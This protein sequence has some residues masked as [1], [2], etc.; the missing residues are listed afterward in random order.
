MPPRPGRGAATSCRCAAR[1]RGAGVGVGGGGIAGRASVGG[2]PIGE[3]TIAATV[4]PPEASSS[5]LH[6]LFP[7]TT[8]QFRASWG[9]YFTS[10]AL[11]VASPDGGRDLLDP[12]VAGDGGS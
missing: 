11:A 6:F 8:A 3:S 4:N 7:L 2:A 12:V 1:A 5:A 10:M 9:P